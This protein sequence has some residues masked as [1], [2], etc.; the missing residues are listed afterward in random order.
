MAG[1]K[2]RPMVS[3]VSV[4]LALKNDWIGIGLD[5]SGEI[6]MIKY[7][8]VHPNIFYFWRFIKPVLQNGNI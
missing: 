8:C 7:C 5:S 4:A 6:D 3:P 2:G 1:R